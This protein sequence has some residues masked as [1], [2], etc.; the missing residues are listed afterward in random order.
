MTDRQLDQARVALREEMN[1]HG[2]GYINGKHIKPPKKYEL[3]SKE[4]DCISMINS[5][6]A[7]Q[8]AGMTDA[9]AVMQMEERAYYNYLADYV[10]LLGRDKVVALIQGQINSIERVRH[11]VY[12]DSEG[13]TYNSI[14]WKNEEE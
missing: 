10:K 2:Y 1:A 4:L 14:V 8:G 9:E 13:C 5:I 3:R 6:L 7:Y 11:G 12:R